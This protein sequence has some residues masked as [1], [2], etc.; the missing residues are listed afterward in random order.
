VYSRRL[1]Q[2]AVVPLVALVA[3]C[4]SGGS[5]PASTTTPGGG[6]AS[7]PTSA[8]MPAALEDLLATAADW[9]WFTNGD[10][11]F[12]VWCAS[13]ARQHCLDLLRHAV[14]PAAHARTVA[15]VLTRQV[16]PY[17]DTLSHGQYHRCSAPR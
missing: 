2:S 3:A 4:S 12:E 17:F 10:D 1:R 9:Q 6:T 14:A 7:L 11:T 15:E 5:S 13:A 16:T 8:A